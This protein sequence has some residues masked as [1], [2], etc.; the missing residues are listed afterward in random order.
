MKRN[1][2]ESQIKSCD[3]QNIAIQILNNMKTEKGLYDIDFTVRSIR[4][5]EEAESAGNLELCIIGKEPKYRFVKMDSPF[6][7]CTDPAAILDYCIYP[8]FRS[9]KIEYQEKLNNIL[10]KFAV[11][12]DIL[13]YTQVFRFIGTQLT[14]IGLCREIPFVIDMNE[15]MPILEDRMSIMRSKAYSFNEERFASY[16]V[17][18][19]LDAIDNVHMQYSIYMMS[20]TAMESID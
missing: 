7:L 9:G 15:I 5:F 18:F 6:R 19:A 11:S 12:D 14:D 20:L 16:K 1:L 10:K 4:E 17:G 3:T 2:S 8:L 13:E